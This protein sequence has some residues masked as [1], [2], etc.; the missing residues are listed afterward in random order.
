MVT[1]ETQPRTVT[2]ENAAKELGVSRAFAYKLAREGALPGL[3]RLR[4]RFLISRAALDRLL[5]GREQVP[6]A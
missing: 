1:E 5:D 2:I 4:G 6:L 3:I